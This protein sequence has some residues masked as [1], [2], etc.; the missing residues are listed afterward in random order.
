MHGWM[1]G[2]VNAQH[3]RGGGPPISDLRGRGMGA[4]HKERAGYF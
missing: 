2:W 3:R 1:D 4:E